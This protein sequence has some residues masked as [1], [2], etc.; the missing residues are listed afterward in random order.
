[1]G[2]NVGVPYFSIEFHLGWFI[3]VFGR[4]GDIDLE[5]ASLIRS[6]IGSLDVSLPM[7]E[8]VIEEW[9]L[10]GRLFRLR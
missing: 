4:K 7:T 3:G 10:D 1:L 9:D 2:G 8:V 5:G 6:I